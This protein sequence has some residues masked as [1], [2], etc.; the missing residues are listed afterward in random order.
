MAKDLVKYFG[1]FLLLLLLQLLIFNNIQISGFINPYV[2]LL[3]I[4]LLP[5]ET[6]GWLLLL[7]GFITGFIIDAF[8]NTFGM[9]TSATL[10]MA[11]LRPYVL[12]IL[13][14]RN[15]SGQK[16]SP[17]LALNGF[18]WI[19]RYTLVLV[20]GHH[21]FLFFIESF[22]FTNFFPTFLR[23]ILSTITT[24]LFIVVAQFITQS[25]N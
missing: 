1:L 3:F 18:V 5:Y 8:M 16:G 17:S 24:T 19:L 6:P 10:F 4:L 21:L 13:I 22:S 14:D 11:F 15:D 2:Y 20:F 9:H 7:L 25:K 23:I 12:N